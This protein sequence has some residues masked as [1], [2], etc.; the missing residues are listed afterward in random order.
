MWDFIRGAYTQPVDVFLRNPQRLTPA[1]TAGAAV[2]TC[3]LS[4]LAFLGSAPYG[5]RGVLLLPM[6]FV[7]GL[8]LWALLAV[9][10]SMAATLAG[11]QDGGGMLKAMT[12]LAAG[13][14]YLLPIFPLSVLRGSWFAWLATYLSGALFMLSFTVVGYLTHRF[15]ELPPVRAYLAC[16]ATFLCAAFVITIAARIAA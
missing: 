13:S 5:P 16:G 6:L 11:A 15:Y 12:A 1:R 2:L 10:L 8:V 4:A 3:L 14:V 7:A 9:G